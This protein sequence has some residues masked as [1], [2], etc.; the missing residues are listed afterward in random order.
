M[1]NPRALQITTPSDR[2][3]M[4]TRVFN[5]PRRLV[6]DAHTKP[7]LVRRWLLGPDGW[8][9]PVCEIDLRVGGRY[10][11]VWRKDA[12]GDE[13]GMGGVF[14]EI[15][16][17]ERIVNTEKFD[18]AW[19][20]GEALD[21]LVLVE[22]GGKTTLTQTMLL[23]SREARDAILKTGMEKG[24]EASYNRLDEVLA[25]LEAGAGKQSKAS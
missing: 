8:T 19:Y 24:V 22:Q 16:A 15:A 7:E 4:M 13:M 11:Y 9:M 20:Q 5:A 23:E 21:T 25:S 6:F 17:P 14:R 10:R 12:T 1:K 3:I 2:E 18:D